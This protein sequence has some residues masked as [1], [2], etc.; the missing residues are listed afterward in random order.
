MSRSNTGIPG[1]SYSWKRAL[2]ISGA[3]YRFARRTGIPT[4][5]SGMERKIGSLVL[6]LLLK[7]IF[8]KKH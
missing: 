3:R 8:G 6:G 1:L 7:L 5:K 4:T 2:G